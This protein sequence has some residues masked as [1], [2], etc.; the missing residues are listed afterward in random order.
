MYA[1]V[2]SPPKSRYGIVLLPLKSSLTTRFSVK[3][4]LSPLLL[5]CSKEAKASRVEVQ[6]R[7]IRVRAL[8]VTG[9]QTKDL[10]FSLSEVGRYGRALSRGVI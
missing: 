2:L 8:E 4:L 5:G 7:S 9:G 6:R 3:T 1:G 10:G